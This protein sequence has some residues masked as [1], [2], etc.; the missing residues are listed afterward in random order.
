VDKKDIETKL[1]EL[2]IGNYTISE[3]GIV[4][5]KGT[6]RRPEGPYGSPMPWG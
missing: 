6:V 5:V 4:D 3:N 1:K 2:D